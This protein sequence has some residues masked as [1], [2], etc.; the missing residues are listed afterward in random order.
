MSLYAGTSGFSYKEWKGTF[1]PET[2][3]PS[4]MLRYYA[5]RFGTVEINNTFYR[6]PQPS[7]LEGW[8]AEVPLDFKF[9]LKAP[10]R[11]THHQ[12]LKESTGSVQRFVETART[13]GE[14]LGPLLFQLPPNMKKD[15]GRLGEFLSL[16]PAEPRSA[17][18]FRHQ[19]WF[20]EEVFAL[21]HERGATLCLADA[22]DELDVPFVATGNWGYLRLRRYEYGD[23]DLREWLA[24]IRSQAWDD[25]Y[26]FFKHEDEGRGPIM[27][28]RFLE[29]AAEN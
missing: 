14:R 15:M 27:A 11:I 7:L 12:R 10:Q 17:F 13:L 18:E 21:L 26:V 3:P 22:D 24:R 23:Q 19:S 5:E 29:L 1:Y 20:D 28:R 9:I 2:L 6:M 25:T 16:L 8:A 4:Q